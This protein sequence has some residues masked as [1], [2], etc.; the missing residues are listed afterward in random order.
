MQLTG[1]CVETVKFDF[2][3]L[4]FGFGGGSWTMDAIPSTCETIQWD[5]FKI[6]MMAF[7]I[8]HSMV[9]GILMH[10]LYFGEPVLRDG[11]VLAL[12]IVFSGSRRKWFFQGNAWSRRFWALKGRI[13]R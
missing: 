6:Q 3:H 8:R 12:N 2:F 10:T 11:K 7:V 9:E 1:L 13:E 5:F 4:V